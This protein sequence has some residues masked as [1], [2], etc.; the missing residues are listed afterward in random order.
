MMNQIPISHPII[1]YTTIGI[2]LSV[3]VFVAYMYRA[4]IREKLLRTNTEPSV[5]IN[6]QISAVVVSDKKYPLRDYYILTS[7]NTCI[8]GPYDSGVVSIQNLRNALYMGFRCLDFEI[9][10]DPKTNNPI[11]SCSTKLQDNEYPI[12]TSE[13]MLFSDVMYYI[14]TYAFVSYGASNFTDPLILNLR[15]KSNNPKLP[16]ALAHVFTSYSKYMV[17]KR[18]NI[19][20]IDNFGTVNISNIMNRISVFVDSISDDYL[21]SSM[22]M[23]FVNMSTKS[24]WYSINPWAEYP[25]T[26]YKSETA[27]KYNNP[28]ITMVVPDMNTIDP[29]NQDISKYHSKGCQMVGL[30]IKEPQDVGFTD[31]F[32]FFDT[33]H[34]SFVLKPPKLRY[35][36]TSY[37]ETSAPPRYNFNAKGINVPENISS[38]GTKFSI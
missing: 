5:G 36:D 18:Y 16:S 25:Q 7:Y 34:K 32:K 19:D 14:T 11:V 13:P 37:I 17:D 35:P 15:I 29:P 27:A 9:F 3:L 12:Q 23:Q 30:M 20:T 8:S 38:D 2:G 10:A 21:K 28:E 26:N 24:K 31:S 1:I 22:F 4:W 33:N 6:R